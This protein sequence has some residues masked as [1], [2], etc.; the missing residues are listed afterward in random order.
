MAIVNVITMYAPAI[1]KALARK[2]SIAELKAISRLAKA[3][4]K[5]QGNLTQAVKDLDKA[6]T[7]MEAVKKKAASTRKK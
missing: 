2:A 5:K 6:I 7:K 1:R 3:T 4:L